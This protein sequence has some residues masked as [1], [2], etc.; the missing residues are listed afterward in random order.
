MNKKRFL[1]ITAILLLIGVLACIVY[2]DKYAYALNEKPTLQFSN[3]QLDTMQNL[4]FMAP[5]DENRGLTSDV[6]ATFFDENEYEQYFVFSKDVKTDSVVCYLVG[7]QGNNLNR[8]VVNFAET[9]DF[10][11]GYHKI[12]CVVTEL[13]IIE[14]NIDEESPSFEEMKASDDKSVECFGDVVVSVDKELANREHWIDEV[15]S[16]D[17]SKTTKG[18]AIFKGRGNASWNFSPKKS[19]SLVFEKATYMLGLGKHKKWNLISNAQDKTLIKNQL[20]LKMASDMGVMYEP[21][22]EQVN[23][24]VNGDYQGV[25]LLT[26]KVSVDK[27]RVDLEKDDWF[28]NFGGTGA[29]QPVFYESDTW[30]DDG[31][32]YSE[33][34]VDIKWPSEESSE[35]L[36]KKQEI[37]QRFISAIEDP[38]DES[39]LSYMDLDSMVRYYWAQEICM[40]YDAAFRSTYAYYKADTGKIYMGPVWDL[41]LTIGWNADKGGEDYNIPEGWKLRTLSWYVPLFEREEF[42]EAVS[43]AYWNG[44]IRDAMFDA[45]ERYEKLAERLEADGQLNYRKWRADKPSLGIMYGDSYEENIIG[46]LEFFKRRVEWIDKEMTE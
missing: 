39:Y 9:P 38:S 26:T 37:I 44:G 30:F 46:N 6:Y 36:A 45:M 24:F 8:Y 29:E 23:L 31:S 19:Y 5:A 40:N 3:D 11:A 10:A 32:D 16:E 25:Y 4:R 7:E 21:E 18:S 17:A 13:P 42:R 1:Y 34:F 14:V 12:S 43:E 28:M 35:E 22:C 41:D 33:P 15:H 2:S 20:F 27:H